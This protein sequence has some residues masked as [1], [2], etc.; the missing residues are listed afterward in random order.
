MS[1]AEM[2]VTL[3][4]VDK[5]YFDGIDVKRVLEFEKALIAALKQGHADLLNKME[6]TKDLDADSAK[7]LAAAIEAFKG[8][9]V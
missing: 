1:V 3:F 8:S 2:S 6:T 7:Q 4:A 5:G 9:W